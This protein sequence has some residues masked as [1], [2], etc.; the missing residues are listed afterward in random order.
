MDVKIEAIK[1]KILWDGKEIKNIDAIINAVAVKPKK[2][3]YSLGDNFVEFEGK[4]YDWI[5]RNRLYDWFDVAKIIDY[6][7]L[8]SSSFHNKENSNGK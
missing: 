3:N 7:E 1:K 8:C 6:L 2:L 4:R 5:L